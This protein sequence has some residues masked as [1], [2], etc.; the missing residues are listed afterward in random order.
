M[1]GSL[2]SSFV[3]ALALL[4]GERVDAIVKRPAPN[5]VGDLTTGPSREDA[6]NRMFKDLD[7]AMRAWALDRITPHPVAALEAPMVADDVLGS[8]VVG[9]GHPLHASRQSAGDTSAPHGGEARR[10]VPRAGHRPL[11]DA[12]RAGRADEAP[13][14]TRSASLNRRTFLRSGAGATVLALAP[15]H[16]RA[17]ATI[18]FASTTGAVGL[19]TQVV[20]R[21]ELERKYDVKLDSRSSIRR[22]RRRRC[23][24]ARSTP[25]CFPSL[26]AADMRDKGQ[27]IVV[28]APLLYIH[29]HLSCGTTRPRSR[30]PISAASASACSTR[31]RAP[32]A[33]ARCSPRAAA[34]TSSATSSR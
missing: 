29:I 25:A 2:G 12:E 31:C 9:V 13:R 5:K 1:T 21:L 27:D 10:V 6:E 32:I 33:D 19:V 28:F 30:S 23:C 11:P 8:E 15:R 26:T 4:P 17:D 34:W 18:A 24:S 14:V 7:P 3:D 16:A 22:P 20:R